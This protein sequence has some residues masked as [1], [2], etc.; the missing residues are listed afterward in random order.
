MF[1][2]RELGNKH[3]QLIEAFFLP[4]TPIEMP[5]EYI[6]T[7]HYDGC[8]GTVWQL[9]MISVE[10]VSSKDPHLITQSKL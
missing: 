8:Q 1:R 7:G 5:P 6:K 9:G 4:G 3:I 2:W 10:R